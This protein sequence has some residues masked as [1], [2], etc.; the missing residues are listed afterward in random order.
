VEFAEAAARNEEVFR[1]VNQRIDEGAEQHHVS[2]PLPF[3]CECCDAS[4]V[5]TLS[6][7]PEEYERIVNERLHFM[8]I[9]GHEND[10]FERVV[11]VHA[12]YVV[13]EKTGEAR[14]QV[15]RD[16]PQ[17]RHRTQ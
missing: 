8:V 16:H 6:V 10:K 11:A 5:E 7:A 3:H 4:C 17:R 1:V 2:T 13:V 15:E 12:N 9:P 14:E